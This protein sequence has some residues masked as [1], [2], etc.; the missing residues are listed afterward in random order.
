MKYILI[1]AFC[2]AI[3]LPSGAQTIQWA[4]SVDDFS[5]EFSKQKHAAAKVLGTP[6]AMPQGGDSPDA[7]EP[8]ESGAEHIKVSFDKA[9]PIKRVV[10]LENERPGSIT[11]ISAFEPG[12]AGH[13]LKTYKA[14]ATQEASRTLIIDLPQQTDYSVQSIRID[15]DTKAVAGDQQID[16]I[17]ITAAQGLVNII[18][19]APDLDVN[20]KPERLSANVNSASSELGPVISPDG[21]TLY[22][23]RRNYPQNIGGREDMEDIWVSRAQAGGAWGPA[24]N[25]GRPLNNESYNFI[26][27]VTPDGNMLLLGNVYLPSGDMEA[28]ASYTIRQPD[29]AFGAPEPIKIRRDKNKSE[30]VDYFLSPSG[31]ILLISEDR[32]EAGHGLRDL[33]VSFQSDEGVWSEPVSLGDKINTASDEFAPFLAADNRSLYFSTSGRPGYGAEDIYLCRRIGDGWQDW[34]EPENLG[35]PINGPGKDAYFTLPANGNYAYYTSAGTGKDETDIYRIVLPKSQ[36]PKPVVLVSGKVLDK[37]TGKPV[38]AEIVYEDLT[39]GRPAGLARSDAQTGAYQIA[40][41]GGENFGYVGRAQGYFGVSANLDLTKLSE[42][43]EIKQDL[44]LLPREIGAVVRLN[45]LFFDFNK[46]DL[47]PESYPELTRVSQDLKKN[48]NIELE[49]DGH[50]DSVGTDIFNMD[51]S[52]RRAEAVTKYLVSQGCPAPRLTIKPFGES[53]PLTSN[54]NELGRAENRRVEFVVRKL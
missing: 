49:I 50:T 7:W 16:A 43:K 21:R 45:N 5:S 38:S 47:K 25:M 28:G 6:N 54:N 18:N 10:V 46:A 27:S 8:K 1:T 31:R 36:R 23:S 9:I 39:S 35:R 26:S 13:V 48:P 24:V 34:T 20:A 15:L 37:K 32:G 19:L 22:F 53:K 12:G 17:G 29:G 3:A 52:K 11:K 14:A 41:P 4:K 40:L 33:Y 51:L 42:Y 2:A 30:R 44:Y